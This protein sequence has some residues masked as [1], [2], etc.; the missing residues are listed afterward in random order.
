MKYIKTYEQLLENASDNNQNGPP[1]TQFNGDG[2][3]SIFSEHN[4]GRVAGLTDS[5]GDV[6]AIPTPEEF[7]YNKPVIPKKLKDRR[8]KINQKLE[9]LT[10]PK[11]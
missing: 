2:S 1:I 6:T 8:K 9:D 3:N 11:N 4:S 7:K 10:K 5:T